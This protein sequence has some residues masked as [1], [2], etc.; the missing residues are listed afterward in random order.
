MSPALTRGFH[1]FSSASSI[2]TRKTGST[3][4][5]AALSVIARSN[6]LVD[7]AFTVAT[8]KY[9]N[10]H[11]SNAIQSHKNKKKLRWKKFSE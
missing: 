4:R 10:K 6:K 11:F 9:Q 3:V 2:L 7:E 1:A 8:L 5:L